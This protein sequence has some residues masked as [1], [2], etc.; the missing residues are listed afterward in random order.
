MTI[1]T[2]SSDA[3]S[4][5]SATRASGGNDILGLV[6]LQGPIRDSGAMS[7]QLLKGLSDGRVLASGQASS[8]QKDRNA[9]HLL[10]PQDFRH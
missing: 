8:S 4:D 1:N 6:C 5:L 10:V 3:T 2:V 9:D 7:S